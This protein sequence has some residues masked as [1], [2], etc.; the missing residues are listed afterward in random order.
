MEVVGVGI[1]AIQ[2]DKAEVRATVEYRKM[3]TNATTALNDTE[4][5]SLVTAA[6]QE[7]S[8]LAA[9]VVTFLHRDPIVAPHISKLHTTGLALEPLHEWADNRQRLIGYRAANSI[10]FRVDIEFAGQAV[11]GIVSRGVNRIDGISFVASPKVL[12]AARQTAIMAAVEDAMEQA[13]VS[14]RN[15]KPK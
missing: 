2:T 4:L 11:D 6:Q 9:A 3:L 15:S 14:N 10:T 13:L 5:A 8:R 7:V 12:N 1:Q